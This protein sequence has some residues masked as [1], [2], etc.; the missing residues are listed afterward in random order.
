ML[1]G[2]TADKLGSSAVNLLTTSGHLVKV[3]TKTTN[4]VKTNH[5][6]RLNPLRLFAIR[7][8]F[9]DLVVPGSKTEFFP[10]YLNLFAPHLQ[11]LI[12]LG[13]LLCLG[14]I[15]PCLFDFAVLLHPQ[16]QSHIAA[17]FPDLQFM[18]G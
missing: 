9:T 5:R 12:A 16:R 15:F 13:D 11:R 8:Y 17:A 18:I 14:Q 7:Y 3:K 2:V 4:R 1:L 10:H 6:L